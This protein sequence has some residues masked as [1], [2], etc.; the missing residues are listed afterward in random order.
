MFLIDPDDDHFAGYVT[1]A[2]RYLLRIKHVNDVLDE[3]IEAFRCLL[4][5]TAFEYEDSVE[6]VS[7][8]NED[9]KEELFLGKVLYS[10]KK[11]SI[12]YIEGSDFADS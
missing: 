4:I 9:G 6:V 12:D 11:P 1:I 7:K 10:F 5:D 3:K 2:Y 8:K